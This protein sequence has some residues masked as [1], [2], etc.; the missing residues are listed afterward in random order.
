LPD[1]GPPGPHL[2]R[3]NNDMSGPGG[4]RSGK[5][6]SSVRGT[7][8]ASLPTGQPALSITALAGSR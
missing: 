8:E 3:S 5:A 6:Y 1:R 2:R 7:I 4:P